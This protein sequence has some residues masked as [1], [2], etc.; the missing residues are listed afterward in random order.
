MHVE[1]PYCQGCLRRDDLAERYAHGCA[2]SYTLGEI[3]EFGR[4]SR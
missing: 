2:A 4:L 1:T 3:P